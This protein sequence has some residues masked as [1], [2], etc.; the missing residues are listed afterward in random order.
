MNLSTSALTVELYYGVEV[1]VDETQLTPVGFVVL[2][3]VAMLAP[4]RSPSGAI[5]CRPR[6][7]TTSLSL[8]TVFFAELTSVAGW[9]TGIPP[10]L[11]IPLAL[12]GNYVFSLQVISPDESVVEDR[13]PLDQS[14]ASVQGQL[15]PVRPGH[16]DQGPLL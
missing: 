3:P 10:T 15:R 4:R 6:M 14:Q 5:W 7:E 2:N 1:L 11:T 8:P 13:A 12:T 16:R 9:R